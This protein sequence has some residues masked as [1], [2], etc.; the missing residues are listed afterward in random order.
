MYVGDG[1]YEWVPG[2]WEVPPTQD[3]HFEGP[4][5]VRQETGFVYLP[6][7]WR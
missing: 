5:W 6:A 4:R 1:R 2:H 7:G 3:A